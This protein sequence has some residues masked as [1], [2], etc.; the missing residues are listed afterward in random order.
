MDCQLQ[1]IASAGM[2]S[3]TSMENLDR[4]RTLSDVLCLVN[5]CMVNDQS[6]LLDTFHPQ[7]ILCTVLSIIIRTQGCAGCIKKSR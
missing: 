4:I 1:S 2:E 6:A 3:K 5:K 7:R